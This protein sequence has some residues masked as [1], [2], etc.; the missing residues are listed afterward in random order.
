MGRCFVYSLNNSV[1]VGL[2]GLVGVLGDLLVGWGFG[3]L[4]RGSEGI[5]LFY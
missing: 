4:G 1:V 3:G 5:G 2:G